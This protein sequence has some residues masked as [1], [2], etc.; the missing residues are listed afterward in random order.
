MGVFVMERVDV[1]CG[2]F[3]G[4]GLT[5]LTGLVECSSVKLL[6]LS[7]EVSESALAVVKALLRTGTGADG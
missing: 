7:D 2:V 3:K 1:D 5:G 4:E 6:P